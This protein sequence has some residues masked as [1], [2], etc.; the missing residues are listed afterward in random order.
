METSESAALRTG[1]QVSVR[2]GKDM[3]NPLF[4]QQRNKNFQA[5]FCLPLE[6]NSGFSIMS[7][8]LRDGMLAIFVCFSRGS[9]LAKQSR[10]FKIKGEFQSLRRMGNVPTVTAIC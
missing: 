1:A 3:G 6:F 4:G 8:Q 10:M 2:G 9:T 7:M 5:I